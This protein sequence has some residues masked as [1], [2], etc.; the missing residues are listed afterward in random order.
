MFVGLALVNLCQ[1]K[2][3]P[4][5]LLFL[6]MDHATRYSRDFL[7]HESGRGSGALVMRL[8]RETRMGPQLYQYA[9]SVEGDPEFIEPSVAQSKILCE[10]D[11]IVGIGRP[12]Q[13]LGVYDHEEEYDGRISRA[14]MDSRDRGNDRDE[15]DMRE[16][17]Y[18]HPIY[19]RWSQP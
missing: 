11:E 8:H 10:L 19:L 18:A 3:L 1:K 6:I 16:Y 7:K 17:G 15:F 13:W 2:R 5:E 14:G 12:V 4:K 9:R